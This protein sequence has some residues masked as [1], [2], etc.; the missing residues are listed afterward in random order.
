M[1]TSRVASEVAAPDA[2][3]TGAVDVSGGLSIDAAAAGAPA[4]LRAPQADALRRWSDPAPRRTAT[5]DVVIPMFR[6]ADRIATTLAAIDASTLNRAGVR[7]ILVDDGSDDDTVA[8]V[9]R[10]LPSTTLRPPVV[11][12]FPQNQ[13][14]GAA[15][16][17]GMLHSDA[18]VVAFVDADLSMDPYV[19]DLALERLRTTGADVVV[20][21]RL[22][23]RSEQPRLRRLASV[24]FRRMVGVLAPTGVTDPQCACKL[25][26]RDAATQV[27]EPLAIA[28]FAF[29][30]ELLMRVRRAGLRLE[31][32][33]VAWTHQP[34]STVNPLT[35]P[36]RMLRDV[37]RA[38]VAIRRS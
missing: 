32:L 38:R 28:G 2:D 19:L 16:R 8:A 11:M 31:E 3:A 23:D 35:E 6:E 21:Q 13:G 7:L 29:D 4:A 33:S 34:G 37:V 15:V 30:V 9:F 25:F 14:K 12:Q 1:S 10:A 36:L 24:V 5:L 20:G 26:T 17:A 18:D 22:V 27:F